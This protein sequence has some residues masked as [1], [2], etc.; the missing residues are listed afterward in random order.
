MEATG[1]FVVINSI[2]ALAALIVGALI[3]FLVFLL[4]GQQ[5]LR[6]DDEASKLCLALTGFLFA[7]F[8]VV[9]LFRIHKD[10]NK[11][12]DSQEQ[13]HKEVV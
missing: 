2:C 7:V 4:L 8:L 11:Q 13:S 5:V 10:C 3:R 1:V 12:T 6:W 9:F